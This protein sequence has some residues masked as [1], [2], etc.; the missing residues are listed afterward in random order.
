MTDVSRHISLVRNSGRIEEI[1]LTK[2]WCKLHDLEVSSFALEL[3]VLEATGG[4][5]RGELAPNFEAVLGYLASNFRGARLVD[6]ANTNNVVSDD[7]SGAEK[8]AVVQTAK[9]S[10]RKN[11]WESVVW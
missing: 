2:I 1:K 6:P 10:L 4:R 11:F 3:A 9:T 5:R 8:L 7:V